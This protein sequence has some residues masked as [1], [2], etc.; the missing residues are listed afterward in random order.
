MNVYVL[1]AQRKERFPG[2]YAPEALA[3]VDE[4]V[5][6][7]D[8]VSLEEIQK[9]TLE[10]DNPDDFVSVKWVMVKLTAT[11]ADIR[12]MLVGMPTI[13]GDVPVPPEHKG[14]HPSYQGMTVTQGRK[15]GKIED[16]EI[17]D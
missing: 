17:I 5:L 13:T 2:Q 8:G 1:F 12:E 6:N 16:S 7:D 10:Q 4:Y 11:P 3:V 15:G 14:N 9:R